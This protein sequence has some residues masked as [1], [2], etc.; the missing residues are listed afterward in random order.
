MDAGHDP[1]EVVFRATGRRRADEVALV[2]IAVGLRPAVLELGESWIVV[3]AGHEASRARAELAAWRSENRPRPARQAPVAVSSGGPGVAGYVIV[4][5]VVALAAANFA[6]G[7]NWVAAGRIDG[8]AMNAGQW[9]RAVTALTLHA[10][11]EHLAG[12][13]FFGSVFGWFAGRYLGSGIAWLGTLAGGAAGNI[14]N[15][16]VMGKSHLAVGAS[17]AVFAALGLLATWVWAG[18]RGSREPWGY[19]WGPV[20]AAVA[21]LAYTGAGGENTDVGAHLWGFASGL[22]IGLGAARL[23]RSVL[24]SRP[25]QAAAGAVSLLVITGAWLLALSA[26]S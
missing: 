21:L 4:L 17:T 12:N 7:A 15:V 25:L 8:A 11:F 2:L 13:L 16:A 5:L 10:D 14:L 19:R 20:V 1:V 6:L 3:V 26:G 22:A 23:P 18:R 24:L 9:W